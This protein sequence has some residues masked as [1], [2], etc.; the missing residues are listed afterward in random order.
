LGG[1]RTATR[2]VVTAGDDSLGGGA[3]NDTFFGGVGAGPPRG[4]PV[5]Y[6]TLFRSSAGGVTVNLASGTAS[7]ADAAGDVLSGIE[8]L[9]GSAFADAHAGAANANR[10]VG[11]AGADSLGGGAGNDTLIGGVGADTL[12]GHAGSDT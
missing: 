7:G 11:N 6:T 12:T 9:T 10:L 5:P 1:D 8:N 3:G 2:C 4:P